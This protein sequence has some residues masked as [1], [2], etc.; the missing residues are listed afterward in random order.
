MRKIAAVAAL[1][2]PLCGT[3]AWAQETPHVEIFGG[4]SY[5][6]ADTTTKDVSLRGW[7][8]SVT[9]NLNHWFGGT[10][11]ATGVYGTP[12]G[13]REF[14]HSIVGGPVFA[15]RKT[16]GVTPFAHVMIGGIRGSRG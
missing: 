11:D 13:T 3:P 2:I 6:V 10:V 4:G 7:N 1:M 16:S 9:E 5:F 15:Y 8:V 14:Q 12:G